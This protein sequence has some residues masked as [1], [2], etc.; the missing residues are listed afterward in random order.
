MRAVFGGFF[1]E[2]GIFAQ[3]YV[4][5]VTAPLVWQDPGYTCGCGGVDELGLVLRWGGDP[6]GDD[7]D[8][9]ASEG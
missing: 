1:A 2:K 7:E 4:R 6:H 9:L 8:L 3:L 5:A